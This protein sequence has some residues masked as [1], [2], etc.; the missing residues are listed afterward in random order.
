M[1]VKTVWTEY[2]SDNKLHNQLDKKVAHEGEKATLS[3]EETGF[4]KVFHTYHYKDQ[5]SIG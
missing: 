2:R 5:Q 4:D 3:L 1:K